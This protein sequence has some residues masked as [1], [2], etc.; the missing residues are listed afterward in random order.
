MAEAI[1][2]QNLT[3]L[4]IMNY[5]YE[6]SAFCTGLIVRLPNGTISHFRTLDFANPDLLRNGT[7]VAKYYKDNEL[8]FETVQ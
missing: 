6:I 7:F 8:I 2:Y 3:D 1:G 5:M 4:L